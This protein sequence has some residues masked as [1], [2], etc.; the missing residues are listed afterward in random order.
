MNKIILIQNKKE[1]QKREFNHI[2]IVPEKDYEVVS[3]IVKS[4][5]DEYYK[6]DREDYYIGF[7]KRILLRRGFNNIEF[8]T[9]KEYYSNIYNY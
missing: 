4:S 2:L 6:V 1:P 3:E 7:L 5:I 8:Y 9:E